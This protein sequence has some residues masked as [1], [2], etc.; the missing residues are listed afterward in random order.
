MANSEHLEILRK[1]VEVW[2]EW[3]EDHTKVKPDLSGA[4][5]SGAD[6]SGA[7]L[8]QAYF[9]EA[10]LREADLSRVNLNRVNLR[11]ADLREADLSGADLR[12]ADLS[13]AD[14]RETDLS[15]ANLRETNLSYANLSEANLSYADFSQANL[16]GFNLS[17]V[18]L[19][20]A[21]FSQANLSGVN[22]S[23][24]NLSYA[25]FSQAKLSGVN[26]S[27]ANLSYAD[28]SEANLSYADLSEA[29]LSEVNFSGV[30]LSGF[31]LSGANLSGVN[32]RRSQS[33]ETNF[34][35][36]TLTGACIEDWN[37]NTKT[38]LDNVKCDYI[39]LRTEDENFSE[40]RPHQEDKVFEPGDFE[41]LVR[42]AQETVDLIFH[43]GIDWQGFLN[44]YEELKVEAGGDIF[45]IQA[46]ENK[47][48]GSF[49]VRIQVPQELD[50]A[51]IQ[52]SFEEKYQKILDQKE[53]D[54]LRAIEYQEKE[55]S[56][57]KKQL[58]Q[59]RSENSQLLL[60]MFQTMAEQQ[61]S[62]KYQ[63]NHPQIENWAEQNQGVQ[64]CGGIH[65]YAPEQKQSLAE[66]AAEIQQLLEQLDQSYPS[67]TTQGRM[68]IATEA[69][70]QIENNPQ[71]TARIL[72][73]LK[74][75]GVSAFEQF[76]NHPAASFIIGAL[77][78][79]QKTKGN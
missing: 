15:G 26:L 41:R 64:S 61:Q 37:I 25:D 35:G 17:G 43:H 8:S 39:F 69:M 42:K 38:N 62:P 74:A 36:A 55:V 31:D 28:L 32:L 40:R 63:F 72:S 52:K 70:S 57:Y 48:D 2:N 29:N 10:N 21:D 23:G 6:L 77:E 54:Y 65:N 50:K 58:E 46:I 33:L 75:G 11:E 20:Y 68:Q 4:N 9:R 18:N 59:N 22:L 66:A 71:L 67:D 16:S 60:R 44:A 34:E 73:A 47:G 13:G 53:Q 5:L 78:D 14:L 7:N 24:V 19:S 76:L 27:E 56:I 51:A 30:N 79:F 45:P 1:G 3:R 49:V 12:E